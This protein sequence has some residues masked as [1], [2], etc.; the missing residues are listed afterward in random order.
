MV[1]LGRWGLRVFCILFGLFSFY[2]VFFNW[3]FFLIECYV[4]IA[5]GVY[6]VNVGIIF[7]Y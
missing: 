7:V 4:G 1:I 3:V 6:F 2:I 5:V